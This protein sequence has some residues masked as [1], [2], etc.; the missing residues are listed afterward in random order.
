M[1][2]GYGTDLVSAERISHLI[3]NEA[4]LRRVYTPAE[5]EYCAAH[6]DAA[7]SYAA[8]F[9]VKEAVSKVLGTGIGAHCALRDIE[10]LHRENGAPFLNVSGVAKDTAEKMG[11]CRWYVSISHECGM[12]IAGVIGES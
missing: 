5:R 11:I 6:A 10:L 12:A 8:C 4:F 1:I 7:S 2:I 3:E 9:A